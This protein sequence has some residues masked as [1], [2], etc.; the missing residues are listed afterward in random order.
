M[1]QS[2]EIGLSSVGGNSRTVH[3][4]GISPE[5][6]ARTVLAIDPRV[7]KYRDLVRQAARPVDILVIDPCRDGLTQLAEQ[8][9]SG[10]RVA[11]LH[12]LAHGAPGRIEFG[13]AGIDAASLAGRP[14]ET[15]IIRDA[16]AGGEVRL[17]ACEAGAGEAGRAFVAAL[18]RAFKA[19][20]IASEGIIGK[21]SDGGREVHAGGSAGLAALF[22]RTDLAAHPV[23]LMANFNVTSTAGNTSAGSLGGVWADINPPGNS[24]TLFINAAVTGTIDL[25][26]DVTISSSAAHYFAA[27]NALTI[28]DAAGGSISVNAGSYFT[29]GRSSSTFLPITISADVSGAGGVAAVGSGPVILSG[30]NSFSGGVSV[31]S[32]GTLRVTGTD[33]M[34]TGTINL[35][36]GTLQITGALNSAAS[37]TI[38]S[39]GG[40]IYNETATVTYSGTISDGSNGYVLTKSGTGLLTLTGVSSDFSGTFNYTNGSLTLNA[41]GA[42]SALAKATIN[43]NSGN[44]FR[45]E[46]DETIGGLSGTGAVNLNGGDLTIDQATDTT[47]SGIILG[48]NGLVK[49][50][51]GTLTM[52]GNSTYSGVH[53]ASSAGT[54]VNGGALVLTGA[55]A[56]TNILRVAS[57]ATFAGSGTLGGGVDLTDGATFGVSGSV[58]GILTVG[59]NT[60]IGAAGGAASTFH[61]DIATDGGGGFNYDGIKGNADFTIAD[62][63]L[64]V[65]TDGSTNVGDTLT[66][67]ENTGA[68]A[69]SGTFTDLEEGATLTVGETRFQISYTGG[70]GNDVTLTHIAAPAPTP[71]GGGGNSGG[72]GPAQPDFLPGVSSDGGTGTSAPGDLE[73]LD[74]ANGVENDFLV[75]PGVGNFNNGQL[76]LKLQPSVTVNQLQVLV[77]KALASDSASTVDLIL[78]TTGTV[79]NALVEVDAE[80]SAKT[81]NVLMN[82]A[83]NLT[84]YGAGKANVTG[85]EVA[86][87][88]IGNEGEN[89]IFAGTDTDT[90]SGGASADIVYG[91]PG[92]DFIYGNLGEDLLYGGQ[93]ADIAYGGQDADIAFGG[94]D[95]DIVYGNAGSDQV[96]GNLADDTLYGGQGDDSVFGGQG[97]DLVFGGNGDDIID[98]GLADDTLTGGAGADT[99]LFQNGD[100]A[101]IIGDFTVGEDLIQLASDINGTGA[102]TGAEMLSR[103]STDADG[104]VVID[105]GDGNTLTLNG[106]SQEQLGADSFVFL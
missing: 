90:V 70:T 40:S 12:L 78:P 73:A 11:S 62:T 16:L 82:Q 18:S 41:A 27:D 81:V 21:G 57:G 52:S 102:T 68:S 60:T 2:V 49:S 74:P 7:V 30:T 19:A 95:T 93:D 5:P 45:I 87:N 99:F 84:L 28:D 46:S 23:A 65:V 83:Q 69:I 13:R 6:P 63:T 101:D 58:S 96:Y 79:M 39:G 29:W 88:I 77:P 97:A 42:A 14:L 105:L 47:H 51:T 100:G 33:A 35:D 76:A 8:M 38:G 48:A 17:I 20:V 37:M 86:N 1:K 9:R 22:E 61:V 67:I 50:G 10:P 24:D 89:Q 75:T 44:G 32:G 3:G 72:S 56:N 85:T 25:S 103:L 94:L 66:I 26:A 34:G 4:A 80:F 64:T 104:N 15:G 53:D 55:L 43:N 54:L 36:N 31:S 106:I 91:N 92:Q 71:S 59:G 98:G